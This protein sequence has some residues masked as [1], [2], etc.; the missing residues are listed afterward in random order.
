MLWNALGSLEI[1]QDKIGSIVSLYFIINILS[2]SVPFAVSFDKRIMLWKEWKAVLIAIIGASIPFL[3]WDQ[4]FT[5]QG[6]W[7][8][9]D[10]Y[11]SRI[12]L[13]DLPLEE[14]LFFIC[15]PFACIFTQVSFLKI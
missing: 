14:V 15:I 11:I 12:F 3:L 6:Y 8:F 9:N 2:I 1:L 7:G 10:T 13:A 5:E 4:Y